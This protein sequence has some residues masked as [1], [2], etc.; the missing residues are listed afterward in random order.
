MSKGAC[1]QGGLGGRI[2]PVLWFILSNNIAVN[3]ILRGE[4]PKFAYMHLRTSQPPSLLQNLSTPMMRWWEH[5][6]SAEVSMSSRCKVC[7][8]K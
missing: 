6:L 8:G 3:C 1:R 5:A 4:Y 2:L 7:L